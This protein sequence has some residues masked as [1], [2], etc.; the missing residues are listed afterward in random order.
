ML[1]SHSWSLN[2]DS[3]IVTEFQSLQASDKF[4]EAVG[5]LTPGVGQN[6]WLIF[7][8]SPSVSCVS[9]RD[10]GYK[11]FNV[12]SASTV[13][14]SYFYIGSASTGPRRDLMASTP[15]MHSSR[16]SSMAM[17]VSEDPRHMHSP[18]LA[19]E[20][21]EQVM[22]MDMIQAPSSQALMSPLNIA[23]RGAPPG[24]QH[25]GICTPPRSVTRH[26]AGTPSTNSPA[27]SGGQSGHFSSSSTPDVSLSCNTSDESGQS[28]E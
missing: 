24:L 26:S 17:D 7:L 10:I 8:L 19:Y 6:L 11:P 1:D 3:K 5:N 15:I 4:D 23:G 28:M 25:H 18:R 2:P 14:L 13:Y 22:L 16:V 27:S 12:T 21:Q 9:A 20:Y